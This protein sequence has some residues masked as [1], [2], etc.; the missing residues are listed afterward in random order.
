M[1][2]RQDGGQLSQIATLVESGKLEPWITERL[3]LQDLALVHDNSA[4][5]KISGKVLITVE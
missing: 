5:G 2:A 3:A 1:G 4:A